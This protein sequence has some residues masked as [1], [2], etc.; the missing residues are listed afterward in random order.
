MVSS[1]NCHIADISKYL[2]Y[3]SKSLVKQIPSYVKDTN[4]LF[5]KVKAVESVPKN[6]HL[7]TMDMR[8]LYTNIS[9]VEWISAVK[10]AFNNNKTF[11]SQN[12]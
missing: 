12:F 11:W 3:H 4:V 5:N 1:V 9:N 2:D 8:P 10:R 6:I 7:V